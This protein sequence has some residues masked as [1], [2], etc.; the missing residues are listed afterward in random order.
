MQVHGSSRLI[1][2]LLQHDL[3]D[4]LWLKV[5]PIVPG[6][7]K[8]L[9]AEGSVPAGLNLLESAS[10][11]TGVISASCTRAGDVKTGS[12]ALDPPTAAE[13]ARREQLRREE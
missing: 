11:P 5:F 7:G 9:C 6:I 8:R 1:Q 10:S 2:T 12:F 4:E 3:V 13:L